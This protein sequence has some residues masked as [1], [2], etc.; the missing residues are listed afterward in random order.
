[1]KKIN[2]QDTLKKLLP[3]KNYILLTVSLFCVSVALEEGFRGSNYYKY[4]HN[5]EFQIAA[6]TAVVIL[7]YPWKSNFFTRKK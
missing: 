2:I 7:V 6:S 5:E 4:F 3:L 1:M